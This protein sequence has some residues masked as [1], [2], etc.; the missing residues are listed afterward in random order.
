[1]SGPFEVRRRGFDLHLSF[2]KRFGRHVKAY[3]EDSSTVFGSIDISFQGYKKREIDRN[4]N[5]SYVFVSSESTM[6]AWGQEKQDDFDRSLVNVPPTEGFIAASFRKYP[7]VEDVTNDMFSFVSGYDAKITKEDVKVQ[8]GNMNDIS[9]VTE[10][11]M[12]VCVPVSSK[13][14]PYESL[15]DDW[16][17]DRR[18]LRLK[19]KIR[20][21]DNGSKVSVEF[22]EV[23]IPDCLLF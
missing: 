2:H 10:L 18:F 23:S 16:Q 9:S 12:E 1:M 22:A 20:S 11:D 14:I 17:R 19:I 8:I 7:P 21:K 3:M 4:N 6:T 5:N 15:Y 13:V